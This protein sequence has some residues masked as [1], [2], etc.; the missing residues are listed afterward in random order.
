MNPIRR[1][2]GGFV[3]YDPPGPELGRPSYMDDDEARTMGWVIEEPDGRTRPTRTYPAG[4]RRWSSEPVRPT[5]ID[6]AMGEVKCRK[7][8][9]RQQWEEDGGEG[10]HEPP[11]YRIRN[12]YTGDLVMSDIL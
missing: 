4:R 3:S 11:T 1:L 5:D 9:A 10:V 8:A 7:A 6:T 12:L 2:N